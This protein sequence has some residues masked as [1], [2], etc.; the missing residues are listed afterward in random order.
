MPG[1]NK[2]R[3]Q[4]CILLGIIFFLSIPVSGQV[5]SDGRYGGFMLG[6][7]VSHPGFGQT[8]ERVHVLDVIPRFSFV[9]DKNLGSDWYIFNRE[10]WIEL[11]ASVILSDSDNNDH[12]DIGM[13]SATFLMALVSKANSEVEP[14]VALGGGPVY[15]AGDIDGVGSDICGNYQ[16]DLGVR[17]KLSNG[18][19]LNFECRY[20]HISNM[21]MESPNVPLNSTKF[22]IGIIIPF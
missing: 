11:P 22:A 2:A 21:G 9:Q 19:I 10:L 15:I 8:T 4:H 1:I 16:F 5:I 6:Y 7:G 18:N 14:Y 13:I 20:H 3:L 17:F 12:H